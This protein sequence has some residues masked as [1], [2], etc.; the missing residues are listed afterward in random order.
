MEK[1]I[2]TDMQNCKTLAQIKSL[3]Q[4]KVF[5]PLLEVKCALLLLDKKKE[6]GFLHKVSG[7]KGKSTGKH[8]GNSNI[9]NGLGDTYRD[10]LEVYFD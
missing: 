10:I 4:K 3:S 7:Y 8:T 1:S 6:I 9:C 2:Q 5:L